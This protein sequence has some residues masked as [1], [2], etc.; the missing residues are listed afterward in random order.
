MDCIEKRNQL[1]NQLNSK[2]YTEITQLAKKGRF[3]DAGEVAAKRGNWDVWEY[4][5]EMA[6]LPH[7][8]YSKNRW[9]KN[10][11]VNR[12]CGYGRR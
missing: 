1:V 8:K 12:S 5:R 3:S 10:H 7:D 11:K 9:I 6:G 2:S 4:C